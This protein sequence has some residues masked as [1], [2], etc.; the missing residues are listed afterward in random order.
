MIRLRHILLVLA[1]AFAAAGAGCALARPEPL[2]E[3]PVHL[4]STSAPAEEPE[5]LAVDARKP[6]TAPAD[7]WDAPDVRQ[8]RYLVIHHSARES[9]N[10]EVFDRMHRARGFDELGYHFVITN[11]DG[12]PD[13]RVEVSRR[14]RTQKWGSHTGGTPNNEY[15]DH[16][17]GICLVGN[18]TS[19]MPTRAQLESLDRLAGYL[20][21]RYGIAPENVVGHR[22]A[23]GASTECPGEKLE[24]YVRGALREK[25]S[26][27][28][29]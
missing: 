5:Q 9:G 27:P 7:E 14:W 10:A 29:K 25:L 22:D 11:G 4:W 24:E 23:P 21:R 19:R 26:N 2:D 16:G 18:F 1:A 8:W 17:I 13:G 15:N 3:I 6:A 28:A 20:A 12:G